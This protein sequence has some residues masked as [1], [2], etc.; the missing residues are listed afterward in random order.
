MTKYER[1]LFWV[2][3]I[4]FFLWLMVLGSVITISETNDSQMLQYHK[5]TCI[6]G[7]IFAVGLQHWSY[8]KIYKPAKE[9][10]KQNNAS[11]RTESTRSA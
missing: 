8:Y 6:V 10:R 4:N 7:V 11:K 1:I 5:Y 3:E 9:K 2:I